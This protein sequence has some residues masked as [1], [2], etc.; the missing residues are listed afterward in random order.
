MIVAKHSSEALSAFAI[1]FGITA[2]FRRH[3]GVTPRWPGAKRA[4]PPIAICGGAT[5]VSN[6]KRPAESHRRE[7]GL[8][9]IRVRLRW[10][11]LA[12]DWREFESAGAA[13]KPF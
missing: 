13:S 12:F 2:T 7:A 8:S 11:T 4:G 6:K 10:L 1:S 9:E 3:T 5:E